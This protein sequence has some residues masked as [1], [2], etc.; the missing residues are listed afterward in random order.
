MLVW[1]VYLTLGGFDQSLEAGEPTETGEVKTVLR[2]GFSAETLICQPWI[3]TH[4][5]TLEIRA[6]NLL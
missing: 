4:T 3:H 2:E 5:H 1:F 6:I